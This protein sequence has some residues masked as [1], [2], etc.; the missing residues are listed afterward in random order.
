VA[1]DDEEFVSLIEQLG[2]RLGCGVAVARNFEA[3]QSA[4]VANE[5]EVIFLG[6]TVGGNDA[7][8]LLRYLAE[9]RSRAYIVL[10]GSAELKVLESAERLGRSRRLSMQP[11]LKKPV[12]VSGLR[13]F[14]CSVIV[15]SPDI[16]A[17]EFREGIAEKRF[18]PYFQPVIDLVSP[19]N[20]ILRAEV[21][22]RWDHPFHGMLSAAEF[23]D[24]AERHGVMAELTMA[25][26]VRALEQ[27]RV[28]RDAGL[29]L[30]FSIN[31][32]AQSLTDLSLP[33]TLSEVVSDYGFTNDMVMVEVTESAMTEDRLE[34]LEVLTRLRMKGFRLAMDDFGTGY[35]TLLELVRLPF[36]E[37]KIDQHFVEKLEIRRESDVVIGSTVSL[38][39]GLGMKVC[40]EGV[41]SRKSLE[42]LQRSGCDA[43]QGRYIQEPVSGDDLM[44]CLRNWGRQDARQ[45]GFTGLIHG[46]D[47]GR[48]NS[49]EPAFV[50]PNL[51]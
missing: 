19:G 37:I 2:S 34:I 49:R 4:N 7:V 43:A 8:E 21:L 25:L 35:S 17:G 20:D 44:T 29:A 45:P 39:H 5:P 47:P 13:A 14:L 51:L 30:P 32:S 16:T 36:N 3:F 12:S 41:E 9:R 26:M 6:L 10:A 27:T 23:I 15:T 11:S 50:D 40:A 42:F 31:V 18:H 1:D 33:D 28:C 24:A 22:A 46:S 48:W 38:A